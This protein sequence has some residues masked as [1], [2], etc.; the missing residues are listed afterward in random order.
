MAAVDAKGWFRSI[1]AVKDWRKICGLSAI[2]TLLAATDAKE[3]KLVKYD[4]F[5]DM[6]NHEVVSYTAMEFR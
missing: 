5:A 3:G 2:T 4:R 1:S 6:E